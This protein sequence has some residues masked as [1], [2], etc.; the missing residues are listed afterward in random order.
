[1]QIRRFLMG[2]IL[3]VSPAGCAKP[4]DNTLAYSGGGTLVGAGAGAL[5]GSLISGA[6]VGQSALIGAGIGLGTGVVVGR[7]LDYQEQKEIEAMKASLIENERILKT[8]QHQVLE[9]Y[10]A[11]HEESQR[12]ELPLDKEEVIYDGPTLGTYNR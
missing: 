3:L 12:G 6:E 4:V 7:Y 2:M 10:R 11:V 8:Q 9:L 1:M 5:A